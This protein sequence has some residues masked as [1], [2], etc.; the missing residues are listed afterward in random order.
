MDF[1]TNWGMISVKSSVITSPF[2]HFI[3]K[4]KQVKSR[5]VRIVADCR[6]GRI[7]GFTD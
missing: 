3:Y 7:V 1:F 4:H 5:I 6:S 2:I